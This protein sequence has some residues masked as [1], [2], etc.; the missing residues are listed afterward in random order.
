MELDRANNINLYAYTNGGRF[1]LVFGAAR[2]FQCP[3]REWVARKGTSDCYFVYVANE[4]L[5]TAG[6][7]KQTFEGAQLEC[8]IRGGALFTAQDQNEL[9]SHISVAE[10]LITLKRIINEKKFWKKNQNPKK[11]PKKIQKINT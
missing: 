2:A 1:V 7:E 9:V 6:T 8:K 3:G 4:D 11:N 5:F 10:T